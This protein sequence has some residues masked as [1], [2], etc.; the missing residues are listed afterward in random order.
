MIPYN[1]KLVPNAQT[2]RKNMTPE[3]K[4]LW[5]KFLRD[6]PLQFRRQVPIAHY[7]LDFYCSA[8]KL[9]IELDGSQ[10]FSHQAQ[11]Y[12]T[13]R[14][15]YFESFGIKVLRYSNYQVM[16]KFKFVCE[17]IDKEIKKRIL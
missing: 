8:A 6:Y 16:R 2:L 10:H 3:E 12:D 17:D 9:A 1:K 7:I 15:A 11:Q 14:D 4:E 13:A 5:Y